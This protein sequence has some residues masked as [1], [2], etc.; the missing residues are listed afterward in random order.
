MSYLLD[1]PG[2]PTFD[3]SGVNA[4]VTGSLSPP[5]GEETGYVDL[6]TTSSVLVSLTRVTIP[7]GCKSCTF[8][9]P[10]EILPMWG[11]IEGSL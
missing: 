2:V 10:N 5:L 4:I 7:V 11:Q 1:S 9:I 8:E 6:A 3:Y